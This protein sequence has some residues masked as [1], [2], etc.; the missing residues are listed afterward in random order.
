MLRIKTD[1]KYKN[2]IYGYELTAKEKLDFDY[3][4]AEELETREFLRYRNNVYDLGDFMRIDPQYSFNCENE[5]HKWDGYIS[6]SFFSG[7]LIK[8]DTE[9]ERVK[10]ATYFS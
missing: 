10:I 9:C 1:H 8:W 7:I 4:S 3:L 2:P 5:F 6:D